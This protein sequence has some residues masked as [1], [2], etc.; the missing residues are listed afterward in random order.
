MFGYSIQTGQFF[1]PQVSRLAK[2]GTR[3]VVFC[4]KQDQSF[5]YIHKLRAA[6]HEFESVNRVRNSQ[7]DVGWSGL[8]ECSRNHPK[9]SLV[10]EVLWPL[11]RPYSGR[12][13]FLFLSFYSEY[14]FFVE[15]L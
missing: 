6:S 8:F 5:A 4:K 7:A 1:I 2:Q 9:W 12:L 15:F 14:F 10:E 11:F 13:C 3:G